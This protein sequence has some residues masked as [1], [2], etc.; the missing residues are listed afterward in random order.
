GSVFGIRFD[1]SAGNL[2]S[3]TRPVIISGNSIDATSTGN[4]VFGIFI[5]RTGAGASDIYSVITGNKMLNLQSNNAAYGIR[6]YSFNGSIGSAASPV[7]ISGNLLDV[8][9]NANI[10]YGTFLHSSGNIF[11]NI[12]HNYMDV[13]AATNAYGGN[14]E[15]GSGIIGDVTSL[16]T[17]FYKNA[18]TIIGTNNRYMLILDGTVNGGNYVNWKENSFT[19]VGGAWSGNY[20]IGDS[21][22]APGGPGPVQ[23]NFG[24]GDTITP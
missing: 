23:T 5:L 10:A 7:I 12:K 6:L 14:L 3:E 1:L 9:S 22:P 20:N 8:T 2:G 15:S 4:E 24:A 17:S 11:A 18:G 13:T 19:P 21:L 16:A